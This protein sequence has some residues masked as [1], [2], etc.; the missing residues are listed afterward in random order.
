MLR[1]TFSPGGYDANVCPSNWADAAGGTER[2]RYREG[3]SMTARAPAEPQPA[4]TAEVQAE[5]VLCAT[6]RTRVSRVRLADGA[7][8]TIEV[9]RKEPLGPGSDQRVQHETA[10]LTRLAGVD[11]APQLAATA[12]SPG[13]IMLADVGG[14]SMAQQRPSIAALIPLALEL[15]QVV[16]DVHRR[17]VVHKD[18]NPSNII[19]S[20]RTGRACLIDFGLA[21]TFAEERPDFTHQSQITGTLAYLAPEQ[22]GRMGRPVDQR[23]DLYALGAT[24]YEFATGRP[25]FGTEDALRLTHDHLAR[26]PVPAIVANPALPPA[27]SDI[28]ARLLEKEPDRRYQSAEGLVH[29]LTRVR[30]GQTARFPLGRRD[31]PMRLA[32]PSQLV[33]RDAEIAALRRAFAEA[34]TG[35]NRGVLISGGPGVGK[36]ALIDEL[37]SIVAGS[38]GW[39]V[40]GKFDQ[41]RQDPESDGAR[42]ALRALGRL[43]LAEPPAE[44]DRRRAHLLELL[45]P[46]AGVIAGLLPEFGVLLGIQPQNVT[47]DRPNVQNRLV[48]A[49][50]DLIR[51]VATPER[52]LVLVIDDLQWA[53]QAPIAF[54][55]A[56]LTDA[57]LSGVLLVDSYRDAEVDEA[58]PLAGMF[59]RWQRL[60]R[61]PLE[62]RLRNLPPGDLA[63][64]LAEMLRLTPQEGDA[65]AAVVDART[66]GNPYDTVELIN[67][68]RREG[69]LVCGPDGWIW[70][71]G[72]VRRHLGRGDVMGLLVAR[73]E[74]LPA[75]AQA[76]LETMACLGGDVRMDLL[77]AAAG[78]TG[79]D[80]AEV[81][82]PA[83]EDGLLVM[84][85]SGE[86]A[87]RFQHD[88]VQQAAYGHLGERARQDLQ[89]RLARQLASRPGLEAVAAEQYL[90][91]VD[92]VTD[93]RE[94]PRVVE[95]L[96][97]GA[98]QAQ[99]VT[100]HALVE[101]FVVAAARLV[102]PADTATRVDVEIDR[103]LA[104]YSQG[105]LDEADESYRLVERQCTDPLRLATAACVQVSSLTNRGRTQEAVAL[106]LDRL[107]GLG[108][109]VPGPDELGPAIDAGLADLHRWLADSDETEDLRRPEITDPVVL[110]A[111][112][113]MNRLLPPAF[114]TDHAVMAWLVL[115][116]A[117]IWSVH[118][119]AAALIGPFSHVAFATTAMV[120]DYRTGYEALRRVIAVGQARGYELDT[121]QAR[122][123]YALGS[124]AW[125]GPLDE[126]VRQADLAREGLVRGG[127]LQNACF[128]YYA[129]L[130]LLLDSAAS[131]ETYGAAVEAALAFC[132]RTG[133]D[134]AAASYVIH[135]Q[136]I[137]ALRGETAAPGRLDDATFDTAER[138]A[139]PEIGVD[140]ANLHGAGAL[141]AAIYDNEADLIRH[142][143]E[144]MRGL[145]AVAATYLT[146]FA[147]LMQ[148]LA[149]AARAR[150][151]QHTPRA[152]ASVPDEVGVILKEL[153]AC[154]AWLAARADDA[155]ANF[156]HLLHLVDAERAWAVGDF[157]SA[158]TSFDAAQQE[159]A[160]RE[161]PWQR[162]LIA[163]R[164]GLFHLAHGM[165]HTGHMLLREARRSYERWGATGAVNELDRRHPF[166]P[167]EIADSS[168]LRSP[169]GTPST[170]ATET[171]DLI[172]VVNASQALS[173]ET[174]LHRLQAR[175]VEI[176]S[177]MTGA[178]AVRVVLY[179]SDTR[180]WFLPG[181]Q[182]DDKPISLADAAE[183]PRRN[184]GQGECMVATTPSDTGFTS[185]GIM[186][187]SLFHYT[188]RTREPVV[189]ADATRDDRFAG[190][191]YVAGLALCSMLA[192]PVT[193]RGELQAILLLENT[194]SRGAFTADRLDAVMLV[195]GQ[196]AVSINNALLYAAL[197]RKVAERT[198][199]LADANHRLELLSMTDPLT[200]LA[201]R[202]HLTEVLDAEWRR[203]AQAGRWIAVAMIDIDWFK[204]Y[205]DYYGHPAG[206]RCL[207]RVAEKL[208]NRIRDTDLVARY[209]GEEFAAIL[210]N[211]DSAV[212]RTVAERMRSGVAELRAVHE[213]SEC[214]FVTVSIGVAATRAAEDGT[215]QQL[216]DAADDRLYRAKRG[217]RNRV[218]A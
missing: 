144:S 149:L 17:G 171:I 98:S 159:V 110:A 107:R 216:I 146:M 160:P 18:I 77:E 151:A 82:R 14:V 53:P 38:G 70:D 8:G 202:R 188:R 84:E 19:L 166:L 118:G 74:A 101:R 158:A 181:V 28:I 23:A 24:L 6:D 206:D 192:V 25:P 218:V 161:R 7:G 22:T 215:P 136:L 29:D 30:A 44:A 145:D 72:T 3:L 140:A 156:G 41:H 179:N 130:P 59:G 10:I 155:P 15:A 81:L 170:L 78:L 212:A 31:F 54:V 147:H 200:E 169:E 190:D 111:A 176:L 120:Q 114:F 199:A 197:E 126:G 209:G 16:A 191:P 150:G 36:T 39:F 89:L 205:N 189:V 213:R 20:P 134:L 139:I 178:T 65:L 83:L 2:S 49:G 112:R 211:A 138:L 52:P 58:H 173:S 45:G 186:P 208:R 177:A 11:G 92:A 88:R 124:A 71:A 133:N 56:V 113:L 184:S 109:K 63:T 9:I 132:A 157:R 50:L 47:S 51:A 137:R 185:R 85:H 141:A 61:T 152:R 116:S 106:G 46:N 69:A 48:A 217:G 43:L 214:G 122:F 193:S 142:A 93:R 103:H 180:E 73:L 117:R 148:A 104:L 102:D 32:P 34:L 201:N 94:R 154:R 35:R 175:V 108:A 26:V 55:D 5:E 174:S 115:E 75:P 57:S 119:P 125:F 194:L 100:N 97:A 42:L 168:S 37:R 131:L 163:H 95:L 87:V 143:A 183:Y 167:R 62:L 196:L 79:D 129:T 195:A 182:D 165:D 123:L 4:R 86:P 121:A 207:R 64:M 27:F 96:R 40:S 1:A 99:S 80:V 60:G 21:T 164:A 33:G 135:R 204:S 198:E 210:P 105:R 127:D 76:M 12:P 91:V 172:G 90:P 68:L 162:A 203:A 13:A 128:T 187:M 67:S 153:D 66:G